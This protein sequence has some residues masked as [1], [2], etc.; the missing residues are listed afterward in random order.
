MSGLVRLL[1]HDQATALNTG[2]QQQQTHL[3]GKGAARDY[4]SLQQGGP[5]TEEAIPP[6]WMGFGDE[7][8]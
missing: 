5:E 1:T 7:V 4:A 3:M 8:G 2:K 6:F